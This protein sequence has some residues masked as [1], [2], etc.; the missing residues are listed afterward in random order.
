MKRLQGNLSYLASLADRK[1]SVIPKGPAIL[2]A[3]SFSVD[4][5][6]K[7]QSPQPASDSTEAKQNVNAERE[8]RIKDLQD[9]YSKLQARYPG[10]DPRKEP[11]FPQAINPGQVAQ[12]QHAGKASGV[13]Q[14]SP[15]PAQQQRTPQMAAASAPPQ[16]QQHQHLTVA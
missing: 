6:L 7:S 9:L 10:V 1:S 11:A 12:N 16:Q 14:A 4:I 2:S 13:N 8:Q 15:G 5:K 3:P